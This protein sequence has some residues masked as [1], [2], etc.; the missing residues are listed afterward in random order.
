MT[1]EKQKYGKA[2]LVSK[3][4][5]ERDVTK[6]KLLLGGGRFCHVRMFT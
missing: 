2:G 5:Y 4:N 1:K 6:G 3:K